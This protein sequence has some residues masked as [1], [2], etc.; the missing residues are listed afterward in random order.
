MRIKNRF[1]IDAKVIVSALLFKNSKPRQA[2]DKAFDNG[3]ILLSLPVLFELDRILSL[4]KFDKYLDKNDRMLFLNYLVKESHFKEIS[5]TIH[6]CRDP[7]DDMYLELAV[8]GEAKTIISGDS[9]LLV[10]NPFRKISI[11]TPEQFLSF[12]LI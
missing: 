6:E 2:F 5:E 8:N 4:E 7:K 9:D 1:V 3:H 12:Q 11:L 10:L